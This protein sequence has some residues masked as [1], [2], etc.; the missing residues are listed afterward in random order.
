MGW[1]MFL[2]SGEAKGGTPVAWVMPQLRRLDANYPAEQ[3]VKQAT[4]AQWRGA[5]DRRSILTKPEKILPMLK[6]DP[7][8]DFYGKTEYVPRSGKNLR[9][10]HAAG[11]RR[12]GLE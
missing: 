12:P 11:S 6:P 5:E 2:N 8:R 3:R 10:L 4:I 9:S 7:I 1:A